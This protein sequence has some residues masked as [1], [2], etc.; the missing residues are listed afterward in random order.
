MWKFGADSVRRVP[1]RIVAVA[2]TVV[3]LTGALRC[4][5]AAVPAV[6]SDTQGMVGTL[7]SFFWFLF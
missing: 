1:V 3:L 6:S 2:W 7:A 5:V 4:R